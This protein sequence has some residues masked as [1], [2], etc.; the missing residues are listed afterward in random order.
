MKKILK[1][2]P[3]LVLPL[4]LSSCTVFNHNS[5]NNNNQQTPV[6][7]STDNLSISGENQVDVGASITLTANFKAENF[8]NTKVT[9]SS[10]DT[11]VATV[12]SKGKV[13]GKKA[14]SAI[15]YVTMTNYKNEKVY[16]TRAITVVA[17]AA[18][19]IE[20]SS[21]SLTM[22][23]NGT[24]K[25]S[26]KVLP[27][28]AANQA[29]T[30]STNNSGV[31]SL[32]KT[33][34]TEKD[35]QITLRAGTSSGNATITAKSVDGNF[36]A[37]CA[38][39]VQAVSGTTV[40]IYMCGAD[41]ESGY[42]GYSTNT[43]E[44]G[45]ATMDLNEI[46]SVSG[47]P[48]DVNIVV[49]T[50]GARAWAKSGITASKSQRWEIRNRTMSKVSE[51]SKKNMGLQSTL[52][53]FVTWGLTNY[54]AEHYGLI[55][56]NHGGAMSGCCFDEQ[57]NDD[58]ISADEMYNAVKNARSSVGMSA[59]LDWVTYDACLMA[60]QDVA[61]YNSYNFEYMLCSQESEAG[62]GYDYDAW[63][64]TLYNNSNVATATLLEKI[65]HTFKK[66]KKALF[67]QAGWDF[68]QTQS[69]LDL[70]KMSAYKTAFESFAS[71]LNSII[72]TNSTKA[73]ALG[74]AI[75][76]AQK[77]GV[78]SYNRYQFDI[79]DAKGALSKIVANSNFSSL[80][81]EATSLTNLINQLVVYEE[82]GSA[83]SGCGL[84]IFCPIE[85]SWS[86]GSSTKSNFS[87][88]ITVA[89]KVYNAM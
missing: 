38:V 34:T 1:F 54:P 17:P 87:N 70:S 52:Q 58:S 35:E 5:N 89:N 48:S 3:L 15:I 6:D 2:I 55:M 29:V 86:Y 25:L 81:T 68:D 32:D 43:S 16:A 26:A 66:K 9:W 28:S 45:Y 72:G 13:T 18:T 56:W 73:K 23:Y 69:V 53:E 4:V 44:A 65:G 27:Y 74:N 41:L 42:D 60:V 64:P 21:S 12:S 84:C 80:S 83:T 62:Y 36:T 71:S 85:S 67:Q 8:T 31:V 61:E 57:Y 40:M 47:Q 30:W 22:S 19:G 79:F 50:G 11:S 49:Q 14:G 10:S 51:E 75:Y 63:L 33:S 7:I 59:K 88:W 78:D 39:T 24:A 20:L 37:T 46:L 82:H 76:S 77:Y